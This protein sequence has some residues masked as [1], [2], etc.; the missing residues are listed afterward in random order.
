[1]Q[2]FRVAIFPISVFVTVPVCQYVL[3]L[4]DL[5]VYFFHAQRLSFEK[6]NLEVFKSCDSGSLIHSSVY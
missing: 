2:S 4:Y 6:K 5:A 1:M 3:L